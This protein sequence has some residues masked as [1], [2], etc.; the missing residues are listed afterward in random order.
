MILRIVRGRVARD[1]LDGLITSVDEP[2]RAAARSTPG[3]VRFHVGVRAPNAEECELVVI[4][5]WATVESA[6]EAYGGSLDAV[7]TLDWAGDPRALRDVAFFEVD[8]STLR[9]SDDDASLL[10]LTIGRVARGLDADIQAE[11]RTRMHALDPEMTEGY[12]GRRILGSEV[13]IAFVSAW[14]TAPA[15]RSLDAP[16]WPDISA[17]YDAFEVATYDPIASGAAAR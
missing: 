15:G 3:L 16:F 1:R 11:L 4:T 12:V 17:R 10:R 9:R 8:E 13:E 2:F 14:R 7:R 6:L 5:F